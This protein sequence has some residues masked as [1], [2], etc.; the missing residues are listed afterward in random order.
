MMLVA[1]ALAHD[2]NPGRGNVNFTVMN[3][4]ASASAQITA[5][6]VNQSGGV[7]ASIDKTLKPRSS[8]GFPITD[9]GLPDN[10]IGSVIVSANK[11]IVAFAQARWEGGAYGDGKTAGAYNAFTQGAT[12][13]YFPSLAARA[14]K[15][16][17]CISIQS[18]EGASTTESI[19]ITIKYYARDGTLSKRVDDTLLKGTQKT[20]DLLDENLPTTTPPGDG[21]LGSAVV[22][23]SSPIAG[24]AIMHWK[25]YSAAY[26]AV[27][28]GGTKAYLPSATRR[29]PTGPW[30]Q[31]TSVIV[32]NLDLTTPAQVKVR[33]YDREGNELYS[34][35]DTIPPNSSHGYNTRW[36]TSDVPNHTALHN[37]LGNNWN[38]S[39][40]ITSTVNIVAVANL[41]WTAD[42]P[43][44]MAATAYTSESS[45]YAEVFVPATFRRE[46]AGTWKQFTG[47]IVQNVGATA[48]NNFTVE[49]RDR[50]GNLLLSYTDSLNPAIS[51]G[52][53]T[54]YGADVPTGSNVADLG[55]DFRGSVYINAPGCELIAIHNTLWP[56]WTDSTTY[57]AFGK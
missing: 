27:T 49:W 4:D 2:P 52:Y 28:G 39:V 46:D 17:S 7:D 26:S 18:A 47:L 38:G 22:E 8:Q 30:R 33:W 19:T 29:L 20:Y 40:V 34:F 3:L 5:Q 11:E 12:R 23:S 24:V 44:G 14:G 37:A 43:V 21:W 53:N 10:W 31:Y 9:S 56:L 55:S 48:C 50:A 42:S 16:F 25:E 51:H 57:N 1:I 45:G 6:Y 54:R 35:D 15:Q 32:Q 13:L 36:T 41:Q